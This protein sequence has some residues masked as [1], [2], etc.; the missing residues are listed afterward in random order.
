MFHVPLLPSWNS[1]HPLIIHFPIA[2]LLV[3]PLFVIVGGMLPPPK[4]KAF[5]MSAL[6]LMVLGTSSVFLSVE[7]GE[8]ARGIARSDPVIK[9]A[10]DEHQDLAEATRV[11]FS[12]LTIAFAALLFVPNML[13]VELGRRVNVALLAVFLIF[14]TT[15]ILFLVNT[16][17]QGELLVHEMGVRSPL[18]HNVSASVGSRH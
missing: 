17:H 10:I 9:A 12:G 11:L 15:G 18:T 7:T 2:L 16:A 8:A 3:A 6:I 13:R 1:L 4:G 5:L 14:Y